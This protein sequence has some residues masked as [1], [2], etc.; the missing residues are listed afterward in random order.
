[1][2]NLDAGVNARNSSV[3]R[4]KYSIGR[5]LLTCLLAGLISGCAITQDYQRPQVD[6]PHNWRVDYQA[7]ADLA[8]TAWWEHFQDTVLNELIKIALNENKDLRIAAARVEEFA[9]QLQAVQSGFYPQINYGGSASRESQSLERSTHLLTPS[10]D[11]TNSTYQT[12]LNVS[13]E[14]DIWGRMRRATEAACADLLSTEEGHQAV[15]L[16]LVSAVA[17]GYIDLLSLD[18]Q[19]KISQQTLASREEYLRLFENK[20]KGGQISSLE[21]AQVRSAYEQAAA[22]IPILE[23]RIAL[24]ENSLSVLLGRRPGTIKRDKT[25]DMLVMPELPQGIPSDLLLRR[26]DIRQSEQNLIAANARIG[27]VR[28]QY[29][30]TI[31]LTGLF[32]FASDALSNLLQSSANLWQV[33]VGAAGPIFSGGRIKGEIRQAKAKQQQLLNDYLSTIQTAFR[34]VDDSLVTI[35]KLREL[36]EIEARHISALK[37]Y[38]YFARSRYDVG[39]SNYIVVL[40]SERNLYA[41]EIRY[42]QTQNDIFAAIV[43]IYKAMGGGWVMKAAQQIVLPSQKSAGSTPSSKIK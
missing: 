31:S 43:S 20:I 6:I 8:N 25:L 4:K 5:R 2:H 42:V 14:L 24:Q 16:T 26:P 40:D 7:A 9:G 32:G 13:W 34:E 19:L 39:Y 11:R 33:G 23:R 36:L 10:V 17:S 15:I 28:T 41:A 21:L 22:Y 38:A 1:M 30:P 3:G 18:K 27:V 12:I 29:F 35:Q 37:D